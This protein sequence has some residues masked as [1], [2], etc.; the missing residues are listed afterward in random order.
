MSEQHGEP[1]ELTAW[2]YH[3]VRD[4]GD[5][6]EAGSGIPGLPVARLL[7]KPIV[8][9]VGGSNV[10]PAMRRSRMG[11]RELDWMQRWRVPVMVLNEGM[12]EEAR[13][14]GFSNDGAL[15]KVRAKNGALLWRFA[16]NAEV[17]RRPVVS[18]K[19][20]LNSI[21]VYQNMARAVEHTSC[22]FESFAGTF[23]SSHGLY[24]SMY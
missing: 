10:I 21:D 5:A 7:K 15:Y 23:A 3:Y 18:G 22:S 24:S 14:D 17:A 4:P 20:G 8:M 6:A 1:L 13:T 12:M 9:K 11:R 19:T 16:T 2:M